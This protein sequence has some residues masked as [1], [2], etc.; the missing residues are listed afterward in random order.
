MATAEMARDKVERPTLEQALGGRSNA[1]GLLRLVLASMVI[2]NHAFPLGDMGEDPTW[3]MS[4]GQASLGSFAVL[5]FFAVSGYLIGKSAGRLDTLQYFWHRALRIFPAYWIALIVGAFVVG[6]IVWWARGDDVT[7]YVNL[8]AGGP[9]HYVWANANLTI[10]SYGV[11]DIF[12]ST[13]PYGLQVGAS[14]L[15]GSIWTLIY[16]WR[17]YVVVAVLAL[18]G[19]LTRNRVAL[20]VCVAGLGAIL[21]AETASPG[22]VA[23]YVPLLND[24]QLRVLSFVFLLGSTFAAYRD[25]I[26]LDHRLGV[27]AIIAV[28]VTLRYGGF[29]VFGHIAVVYGILYLAAALPGPLKRIGSVNDYSYGI[30]VYGF[31]VQQTLAYVGVH[32]WGYWPYVVIA[33]A[34]SWGLAWLSWH[35]VEKRALAIKSWGPG[36]GISY[37]WGAVASRRNRPSS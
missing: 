37:W 14:V 24:P 26:V 28:A 4:R 1:F 36:K 17:M 7:K 13:T 35:G 16:E 3:T 5:G 6:P 33:L 12:T 15:N 2:F 9:I 31:L 11:H 34:I 8:S 22:M 10:E 32:R 30:Y 21:L 18:A 25:K 29:V 19:L 23:T 20:L 27:F